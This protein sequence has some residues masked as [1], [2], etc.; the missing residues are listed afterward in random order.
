[1]Y[2]SSLSNEMG[3]TANTEALLAFAPDLFAGF[4]VPLGMDRQLAINVIRRH[5]GFAPLYRP[6]PRWMMNA[7]RDW[8][9]E[10]M[11]IWEKLYKTT[12]LE[13]NPIWNTD[14]TERT[15]DVRTIDRDTTNDS[16]AIDRAKSK[17]TLGSLTTG[18]RHELTEGTGHEETHGTSE[19]N[20]NTTTHGTSDGTSHEETA[21]KSVTDTTSSATT[22]TDT[23]VDGTDS[24]TTDSTKNLDQTV[25][26]DI[27]PE[28]A[29]DY[30]PDD[31]SHTVAEETLK[32]TTEGK[33][34]E[35]TGVVGNTTST[36]N[37][38]T[39][40]SG[41]RDG[42]THGETWGTEDTHQTGETYGTTDSSTTGKADEV[43]KGTRQDETHE[44]SIRHADQKERG[45]EDVTE[46]YNHG[47][48]RQGN[49]GVTTTQQMI[50]AERVTVVYSVYEQIANSYHATFCLDVY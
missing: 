36:G 45:T 1:M 32:T 18:D 21:G 48:I 19:G 11:P 6:D 49:I 13:Y 42:T 20:G 46:T 37:S 41:T 30:Q 4:M 25:T 12:V 35:T 5:H 22:V 24:E 8:T 50:D 23:T 39:N 38:T 14:V 31:Q 2:N 26:R 10:N 7:I 47:W 43:T 44:K 33:H 34:H 3:M 27:S 9:R 17:G 15:T 29:P 16:T 28:N 40:T